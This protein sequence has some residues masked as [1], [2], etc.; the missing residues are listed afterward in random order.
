MNTNASGTFTGT[1]SSAAN[2]ITFN[3]LY[4]QNPSFGTVPNMV[5]IPYNS[6]GAGGSP[7]QTTYS[8][9]LAFYAYSNKDEPTRLYKSSIYFGPYNEV[10][11][12]H[13]FVWRQS[14]PPWD[15]DVYLEQ[16]IH[17]PNGSQGYIYF[18]DENHL[19]EFE[20]WWKT[21]SSHFKNVELDD[22]PYIPSGAINGFCVL[23]DTDRS[24]PHDVF[25]QW[26][27]IVKNIENLAYRTINGWIFKTLE[28]ASMFKLTQ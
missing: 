16:N 8:A 9:F 3:S 19:K 7:S 6:Y 28:D 25:N 27:F 10:I 17:A 4:T 11:Q 13:L 23:D 14:N 24:N 26:I 2:N 1:L 12:K 15:T 18:Y 20:H 22:Y 21:Y 5:S